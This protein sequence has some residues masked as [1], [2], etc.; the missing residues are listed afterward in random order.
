[1]AKHYFSKS[2]D[3]RSQNALP[4]NPGSWRMPSAGRGM[5]I[6]GP[7]YMLLGVW[8]VAATLGSNLAHLMKLSIGILSIDLIAQ[9]IHSWV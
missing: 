2:A 4:K 9:Q 3:N 8:A 1:M 6:Q 7:S 5:G